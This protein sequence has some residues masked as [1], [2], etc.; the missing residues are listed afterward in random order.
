MTSHFRLVA[1]PPFERDVRKL[2]KRSPKLVALVE[3]LLDILEE[4]PYNATGE[5]DIR[6][7][8]DVLSG[9]G[10][11]RIRS[12]DYRLRYDIFGKD[13]VLYSFRHRREIYRK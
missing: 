4:D 1:T 7:L 3:G 6:K 13:V 10:K 9:K 11:W 8:A 2:T 12:G 5:H